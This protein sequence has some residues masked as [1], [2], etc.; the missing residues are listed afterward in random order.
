MGAPEEQRIMKS[1]GPSA[2]LVALICFMTHLAGQ[3]GPL[4]WQTNRAGAVEAARNSGKLIL[5]LAGRE[6]CGY[7]QYMKYTVCETPSVRR[8]I[9]ANY[10]CWF[11]PID[12]STEWNAYAS[13]LGS[14]TLPLMCVIDPGSATTYLDRTTGT[15]SVSD[16]QDRVSSHL[17]S[18]AIVLALLRGASSRLRWAS[19]SQ[20]RYRVLK[21]E[22]LVHWSF[23]GAVILGN[24]L[25]IEAVDSS[26]ASRCYYRVMGFR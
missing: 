24:G 15:Q 18:N 14:F 9:D 25:P 4:V 6:T 22:D 8:V 10:V 7:C 13:G 12:T 3:A 1:Y 11:C 26:T 19:E 5:L 23:V 21:S 16:F 20:L 17:P 2:G